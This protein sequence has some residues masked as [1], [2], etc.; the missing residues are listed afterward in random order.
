MKATVTVAA[1]NS[2]NAAVSTLGKSAMYAQSNK[3]SN[4]NNNSTNQNSVNEPVS[5]PTREYYIA[6]DQHASISDVNQN[7]VQ[8]QN[9]VDETQE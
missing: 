4:R 1:A 9:D 3:R 5:Q 2:D 8:D 7:E 6:P